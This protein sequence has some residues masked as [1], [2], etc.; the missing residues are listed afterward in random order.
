ME[1]TDRA[2]AAA[3]ALVGLALVAGYRLYAGSG[4]SAPLAP[5][6]EVADADLEAA[7]NRRSLTVGPVGGGRSTS[8]PLEVY[9]S[10]VLAGEGE[11]GAPDATQQALAVAIRTFAVVNAGR[12]ARDGFDLC[13]GT[14]CQVPRAATP[15]TRRAA[16]A[17]A[18]SVLVFEG[19]PA[20]V[21][22]SAS[23]GGHSEDPA[24]VWPGA[25]LPYLRAIVD[26]V[27]EEDVPWTLDRTLREIQQALVGAGFAGSRLTDVSVAARSESGRATRLGLTGLRPATITGE[28][29]RTVMGQR[30]LR[31]TAF[32]VERRGSTFSLYVLWYVLVFGM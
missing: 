22:Y 11:P 8:I 26:D 19:A 10:R 13:D 24:Y 27:H 9:V 20:E 32:A 12:H 30:A 23:C 5:S 28:S 2:V 6:V 17:T 25:K 18:G 3:V 29:F 15:A 7:G 14:H 1:R 21:F 4:Q 16:L 31:S